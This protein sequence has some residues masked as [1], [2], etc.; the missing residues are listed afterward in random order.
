MFCKIV[1]G[2]TPANKIAEDGDF[3]AFLGIFPKFPG[4]TVVI[5]K[6]H[7]GESYIYKSFSDEELAKMHVFT[8][9][10][11]LAIDKALGSFRCIQTMEGMENREHPHLK[12]FPV[13]EGKDYGVAFEGKERASDEE[14][15]GIVEK[16]GG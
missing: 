3:V 9:K 2:E 11:A 6:K 5:T 8:K 7:F 1:R 16:I 13:Y 4:M 10:V 14:L 12:L 15:K